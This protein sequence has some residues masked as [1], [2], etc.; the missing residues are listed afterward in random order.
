MLDFFK[1]AVASVKTVDGKSLVIGAGLM[2]LVDHGL[3][4]LVAGLVSSALGLN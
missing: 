1:A 2:W 4:S 3:S